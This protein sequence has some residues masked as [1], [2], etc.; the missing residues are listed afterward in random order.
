[1]ARSRSAP[2]WGPLL[3]LCAALA[4]GP[5]CAYLR[6][7]QEPMESERF[8]VRGPRVAR[9]AVVLLPGVGDRPETFEQQ[10][11]VAALRR[12]APDHDVIAA[13]A[14]FGY[15]RAHSLVERL[16]RDVIGP[17]RAQGYRE[18][19]LAGTSMGGFGAV[20]YARMHPERI[21]GLLLFAPYMGSREVADE[22]VRAGGLCRYRAP[23]RYVDDALGFARA[24]FGYL[25]RLACE[26][27]E[28]A[29]WLAVGQNDSLLPADQILGRALKPQ[30]FLT[31]PG[32]HGWKVWTPALQ[33]I[34]PLAIA[35]ASASR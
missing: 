14:H 1:M 33:R 31:L 11:F 29:V 4:S 16:E 22:V 9:G 2:A 34:A 5:G 12:H 24:N 3:L 17:L 6:R 10:G 18:L 15:Y 32:G 7:A 23:E 21:A 26:P 35:P 13:D 30:R 27:S 20:A 8:V 28:V 19:W 25:R